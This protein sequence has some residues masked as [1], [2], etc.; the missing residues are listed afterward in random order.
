MIDK[1]LVKYKWETRL[2]SRLAFLLLCFVEQWRI[3]TGSRPDVCLR[4]QFKNDSG[5]LKFI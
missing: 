1:N 2:V 4:L 5:G 3:F